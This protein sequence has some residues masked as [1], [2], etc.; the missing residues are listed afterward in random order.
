MAQCTIDLEN[1]YFKKA[2][3]K[4]GDPDAALA[5]QGHVKDRI[6]GDHTQCHLVPQ[7][8]FGNKKYSHLHNKV[9]R[10]DW[11]P[12]GVT[13]KGRKT[14]RMIVIVPDPDTIPYRMIAGA[15]Y[16]KNFRESLSLA[17]LATIYHGV[18]TQPEDKATDLSDNFHRMP[19]ENDATRSMCILCL[20]WTFIHFESAPID[21]AEAEHSLECPKRAA[22]E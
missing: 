15:I 18:M 14:W 20:E 4:T 12:E 17:E 2:L 9:W 7:R 5:A 1:P 19:D 8:F 22:P 21:A 11:A 16:S 6:E 13:S 10:Y 3:K